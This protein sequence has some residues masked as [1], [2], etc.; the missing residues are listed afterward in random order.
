M[1]G[2][3]IVTG[4]IWGVLKYLRSLPPEADEDIIVMTDA[5]DVVFQLPPKI[6]LS[7]YRAINQRV[8]MQL[9][10]QH[11]LEAVRQHGLMQSIIMGAEKYC[12]PLSH[13]HPACYAVPGSRLRADAYGHN[14]D[15]SV[16]TNRPRWLNSGTV[17]G[18]VHDMRVLYEWAHSLW[19]SYYGWG[20][21][22]E[23]FSYIYGMQELGRQQ[24][25]GSREWLFGFNESF[26]EDDFVAVNLP[27][28]HVDYHV[29]VDSGSEIFQSLNSAT[30]DLSPVVHDN[31]AEVEKEDRLHGTADIY[32]EHF[33]FPVDL[34]NT[35]PPFEDLE[36][37]SLDGVKE[38]NP[39]L[40]WRSVQLFT[41]FHS[42]TI[43][44]ALHHNGNKTK[45]EEWWRLQWWTGW[46]RELTSKKKGCCSSWISTDAGHSIRW[47]DICGEYQDILFGGERDR[48]NA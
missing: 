8:N 43:P 41:D 6:L 39:G 14:T 5:F 38:Q 4:K 47:D 42:R 31:A 9:I 25:R 17:I 45:V 30:E 46:G 3:D 7:R 24:L 21:D 16:E 29:G 13:R 22:Q 40:N 32:H 10:T 19:L 11:G 34:D 27:V 18:P 20:G 37:T 48:R 2:Y 28:E 23:Y 36:D 26:S 35:T 44:V 15:T 33:S 12:W 1:N